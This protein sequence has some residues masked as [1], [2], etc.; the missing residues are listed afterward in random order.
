MVRT[1]PQTSADRPDIVQR[2]RKV[3]VIVRR[4]RQ[5]L[6]C[7]DGKLH[8][9]TVKRTSTKTSTRTRTTTK[10][11]ST[12]RAHKSTSTA[13]SAP[14]KVAANAQVAPTPAPTTSADVTFQTGTTAVNFVTG[15]ASS[16]AL[17]VGGA[18]L[19]GLAVLLS[20]L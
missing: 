3:E 1:S 10:A 6:D 19:V 2:D 14:T 4:E 18:S 17:S 20:A 7:G 16:V 13:K 11:K 5:V 15:G 8:T 12:T 9:V